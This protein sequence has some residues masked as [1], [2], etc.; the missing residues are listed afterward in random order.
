M[1]DVQT[2]ANA[3]NR[4]EPVKQ[5]REKLQAPGVDGHPFQFLEAVVDEALRKIDPSAVPAKTS[6]S[7]P[8]GTNMSPEELEKLIK[9]ARDAG[10]TV[11]NVDPVGSDPVRT[12]A[13]S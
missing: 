7:G 11:L 4:K 6:L 10:V 1:T 12:V 5:A 8:K 3:K 9:K 2:V 13:A